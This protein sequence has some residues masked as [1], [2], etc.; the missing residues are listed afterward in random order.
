MLLSWMQLVLAK[1]N[2]R[3]VSQTSCSGVSSTFNGDSEDLRV[4]YT[5][6]YYSLAHE[7]IKY[8]P[9]LLSKLLFTLEFSMF[10]FTIDMLVHQIKVQSGKSTRKVNWR[11]ISTNINLAV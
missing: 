10:G 11:R 4:P 3:T 5:S 6:S 8:Q 1:K 7:S 9:L 2:I